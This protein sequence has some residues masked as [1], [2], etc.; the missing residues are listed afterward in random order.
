[1]CWWCYSECIST[2]GKLK[3]LPDHGGNRTRDLWF[4]ML[5]QLSYEV[6]SVRVCDISELSLVLTTEGILKFFFRK[7]INSYLLTA[8]EFLREATMY[9]K[10]FGLPRVITHMSI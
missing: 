6:K 2:L 10:R 1:M 5:C 7:P 3:N 4:P 8:K 9:L